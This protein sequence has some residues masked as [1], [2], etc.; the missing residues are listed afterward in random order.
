LL[1]ADAEGLADDLL[2]GLGFIKQGNFDAKKE[3]GNIAGWKGWEADGIFF[4]G[5]E[6]KSASGSGTGECVFYLGGHEAVV[7]GK[8]TLV[9]DFRAQFDQALE[10]AFRNGDSGNGADTKASEVGERFFFAGDE[11]FQMKGVMAAGVDGG[12]PVVAADLFF[13]LGVFVAGAF[14]EEDE[15]GSAE[16]IGGFAKDATGEDVL[17]AERVLSIDEKKVKAVAEAEVLKAVVEKEGI[18]LVV[19]DGVASGFDAV[20]VHK[21][22]DAWEVAGEHEGLV[23]GL[24]GIKENRFSVGDN[25]GWRGSTAGEKFVREASKKGFGDTFVSAAEDGDTSARFLEGSGEFF[26]DGCFPSASDGEVADAD[27]HHTNRVAAENG[28]LVKAGAN[29]HDACVDGGK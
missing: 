13:D 29:A 19:A 14:G 24:S 20:G 4:G 26:D 18:G 3:N 6:G 25:A 21:D 1:L 22:G 28:V 23:A 2:K 16:C 7:I 27:D 10:E 11:V 12:V 8:G 15:I 5:D 17:V 9:D